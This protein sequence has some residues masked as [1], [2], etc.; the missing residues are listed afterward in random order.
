[1]HTDFLM[2][3]GCVDRRRSADTDNEWQII[4][5]ALYASLMIFGSKIICRIG[6]FTSIEKKSENDSGYGTVPE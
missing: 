2:R 6:F 5:S 3:N 1:T 4:L